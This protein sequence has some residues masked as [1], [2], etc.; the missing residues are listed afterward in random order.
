MLRVIGP[1]TLSPYTDMVDDVNP[2]V[3]IVKEIP[4]F[5]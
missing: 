3:L 4:S 2:A 5:P 1:E